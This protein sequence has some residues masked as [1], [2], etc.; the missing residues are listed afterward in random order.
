MG[1][2]RLGEKCAWFDRYLLA[3]EDKLICDSIQSFK[4]MYQILFSVSHCASNWGH[5]MSKIAQS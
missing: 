3:P 5:P 1:N 2:A 4:N